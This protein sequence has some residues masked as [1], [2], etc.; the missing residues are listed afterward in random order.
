MA[1]KRFFVVELHESDG[2][3][4]W[5]SEAFIARETREEAVSA[6]YEFFRRKLG[7]KIW[8]LDGDDGHIYAMYNVENQ[9]DDGEECRNERCGKDHRTWSASIY[10][11]RD[12]AGLSE[13]P[14][15][16]H[17]PWHPWNGNL[18]EM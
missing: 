18:E 2:N 13:E 16:S 7:E 12:D 4:N 10:F 14:E 11:S 9:C 3:D 1:E 5:I 8:S 17:S 6:A 15:S